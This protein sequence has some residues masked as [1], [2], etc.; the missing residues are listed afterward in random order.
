MDQHKYIYDLIQ[1]HGL[2][3]IKLVPTLMTFNATIS[4]FDRKVLDDPI[5][6]RQVV[7]TL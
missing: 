5:E 7:Y 6:F 2:G 3:S 1:K 4:K